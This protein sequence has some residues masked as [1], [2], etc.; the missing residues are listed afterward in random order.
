MC[1]QCQQQEKCRRNA[2]GL[3]AV[4]RLTLKIQQAQKVN[5]EENEIAFAI[6]PTMSQ[7]LCF[8]RSCRKV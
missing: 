2:S 4:W 1:E 7:R 3:K 8:R 6:W 5:P